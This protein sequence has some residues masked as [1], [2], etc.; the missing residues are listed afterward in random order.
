[1]DYYQFDLEKWMRIIL[2]MHAE[3]RPREEPVPPGALALSPI[4]IRE[5][6]RSKWNINSNDFVCLTRD[7]EAIRPTLYRVG[8]LN[9]PKPGKDRYFMLLKHVEASYDDSITKDTKRKKHLESRWCIL[10][11]EGNEK[12]EFKAFD[13]PYLVKDSCIYSINSRY[14]NI[15]TGE[16]YCYAST[17]MTTS[18]FLF[19]DNRY[20]EDKSKRG[21]M[22]ISLADG[23]WELFK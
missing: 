19:L 7:G 6:Y 9:T 1:M 2:T 16:L 18:E 12:V 20:D 11:K 8:G 3:E 4:T 22:K 5:D 21:V 13:S 23:T 15:E 17:S 10:D 14:Y